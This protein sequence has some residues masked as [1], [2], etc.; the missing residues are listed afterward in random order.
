VVSILTAVLCAVSLFQHWITTYLRRVQAR[1]YCTGVEG[2][3]GRGDVIRLSRIDDYATRS[4]FS[5]LDTHTMFPGLTVNE[6]AGTAFNAGHFIPWCISLSAQS[7][8]TFRLRI[9]SSWVAATKVPSADTWL[10]HSQPFASSHSHFLTTV[11]CAPDGTTLTMCT[12]NVLKRD[13]TAVEWTSCSDSC[14]DCSW[15][16]TSACKCNAEHSGQNS[17]RLTI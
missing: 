9:Y 2:V 5:P 10:L 13:G 1:W 7:K 3:L 15:I 6:K 16:V 14:N 8:N 4:Q 12:C 17:S 11:Q